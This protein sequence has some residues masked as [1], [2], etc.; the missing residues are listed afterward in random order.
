[1]ATQF[2]GVASCIWSHVLCVQCSW[3]IMINRRD[4]SRG[5][6]VTGLRGLALLRNCSETVAA[7]ARVPEG[8]LKMTDANQVDSLLTGTMRTMVSDSQ[9]TSQLSVNRGRRACVTKLR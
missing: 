1:M 9:L 7:A 8:A 5:G 3:V 6:V 2:R 4:D